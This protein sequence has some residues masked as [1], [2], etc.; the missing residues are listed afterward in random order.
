MHVVV[1]GNVIYVT[2]ESLPLNTNIH[3]EIERNKKIVFEGDVEINQLK[4]KFD[5]L[6]SF[7][8]R[9]CSFANGCLLMT[10]TG[11]VPSNEFTLQRQDKILITIDHIGTLINT[12]E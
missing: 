4:R 8:F 3:L 9:E 5:E 6:V 11:I 2:N 1:L 7:L 10:G 12:V